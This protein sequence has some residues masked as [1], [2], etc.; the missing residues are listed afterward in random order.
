MRYLPHT[1]A[2]VHAM[3]RR[4]G[5]ASLD[6]LFES[7]PPAVRLREPL[8]LEPALA[9]PVLMARLEQLADRNEAASMPSFLGAGAY[10]HHVP[11]AVDQLLL[12]SEFYTAYT[13][14]Q[15]EV[16]QGTLQAIF[17]FQT[18]VAGLLG[19][20]VANA[21]L[22]DGASAA[23]EAALMARRITRRPAVLVSEGLHPDWV[24]TVR[25]YLAGLPE[26]AEPILVPLDANG[27]TDPN[28]LAERLSERAA[29]VLVGYPN[30]FGVVEPIGPLA[31]AA[32]RAGALLVTGTTEPY[33]LGVLQA[34]G[35]QGADIAVGEGQPLATPPSFGGPGVGLMAAR[36]PFLR[37]MP[38]RIVGQTVDAEG[39]R[40]FVL[41][42][43]T[44]EQHIRRERA[45]SN[46]CTNQGLVALAFTIRL[47]L[48][49]RE[50]FRR[51][52]LHALRASVYLREALARNDRFALPLQAPVYNELL[53]RRNAGA[54]A[55]LLARVAERDRILAGV[56]LS[57]WWPTRDRDFLLATTELHD[58]TQLDA[59][60]QALHEADA[61]LTG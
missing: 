3:L 4:I 48:L 9:E 53:V 14:Y 7:I 37:Q 38:G 31:E 45:T 57:R 42:L 47:A 10:V 61:A 5:V 35:T 36:Q 56:P 2:E 8:P 6:E 25:T 12:R 21:S 50:G 16:S 44:R 39:R 59:L 49:G 17:E 52:A 41:T 60:L 51:A 23:A 18:M 11:P 19:L 24:A 30:F 28:A 40:G 15:A 29:V 22:Y 27:R 13:P 54:A 1:E 34:P 46:I 43:S 32:H 33:A 58:R 55:P 26:G 20:D